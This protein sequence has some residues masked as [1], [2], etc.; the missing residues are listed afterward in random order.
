MESKIQSKEE[1]NSKVVEAKL[2][3]KEEAMQK[4]LDL[5]EININQSLDNIKKN[6]IS[7]AGSGT[8]DNSNPKMIGII[9]VINTASIGTT[10]S[11]PPTAG[12]TPAQRD[13]GTL[14]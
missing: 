2:K 10:K 5:L 8:R 14:N 4:Q 12:A 1:E 9:R 7:H 11:S 6:G 3:A 13:S